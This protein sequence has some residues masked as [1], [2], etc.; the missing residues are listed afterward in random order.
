MQRV[1]TTTSGGLK[2]IGAD[3]SWYEKSQAFLD[4]LQ[5]EYPALP[6]VAGEPRALKAGESERL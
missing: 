3:E 4:V 5:R 6:Q 2:A 1:M